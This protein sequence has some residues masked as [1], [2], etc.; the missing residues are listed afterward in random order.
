[1]E[2]GVKAGTPLSGAS[3]A[4]LLKPTPGCLWNIDIKQ[5]RRAVVSKVGT[6]ERAHWDTG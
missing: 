2:E 3:P 6:Q 5:H 1:M 4:L